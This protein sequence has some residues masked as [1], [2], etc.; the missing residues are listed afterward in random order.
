MGLSAPLRILS[1]GS[2]VRGLRALAPSMEARIGAPA[3]IATDHGH[4]IAAAMRAGDAQ[5]DAVLLP[6]AMI[7]ALV[8]AGRLSPRVVDLGAVA[9]S[10]V[11]CE[12]APAPDVST[13]AAL[14]DALLAASRVLLTTAPSGEHMTRVIGALGVADAIGAKILRFDRSSDINAWLAR[15]RDAQALGFGPT[16]EIAGVAGVAHAGLVAPQAQMILPYAAALTPAAEKRPA[17]QAFLAFLAG[18]DARA[19]FEATGVTFAGPPA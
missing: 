18:G 12:G 3:S 7:D 15:E 14:R 11:V 1:A 5:A 16:T 9:T 10:A 6:R 2:T 13:M 19:A 4:N 17:A 8:A